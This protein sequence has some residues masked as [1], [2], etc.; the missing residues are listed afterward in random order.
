MKPISIKR[1]FLVLIIFM[2]AF[3]VKAQQSSV[4][5]NTNS[6]FNSALKLYNNKSYAAAQKTFEKV[7]QDSDKNTSLHSDA[8]YFDAMCAI[9]L[10]QT[11]ADKKVLRF[12][13]E[14]PASSKKNKAY[15]NVGNYYF[16]DHIRA[17][18]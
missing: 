17:H 14:N 16:F 10:N 15:F 11:D 6:E 18:Q 3:Y 2:S 5:V 13:E 4:N 8:S 9:K 1:K 12:V 7:L